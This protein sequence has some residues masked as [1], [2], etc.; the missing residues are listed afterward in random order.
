VPP[1]TYKGETDPDETLIARVKAGDQLAFSMLVH[2]YEAPLFNYLRRLLRNAA[3]AED[4]FQETFL[5]V[6]QHVHRFRA[7]A[8]F[9][10]W[11]YQI[12][13]N[14]ARDR[15]RKRVRRSEVSLDGTPGLAGSI[16]DGSPST[17]AG[18][19]EAET[20][21]RLEAALAGLPLKQRAVFLM[22]RYE[23]MPYADI[24]EALQVPV[25]TVKSRMNAAVQFLMA[26]MK[27]DTP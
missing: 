18:A 19:R 20:V 16:P 2:R 8:V 5:R 12:A 21:A 26:A 3:D 14:A 15:L 10:P 17:D 22:A 7:D 1:Q 13:T 11:L 23:G 6:Y 4:V 9:R 25:G 27:D 24:A